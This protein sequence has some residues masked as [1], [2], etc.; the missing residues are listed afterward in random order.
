MIDLAPLDLA[1]CA[2]LIGEPPDSKR[3]ELIYAEGGGNPFYSLQLGQSPAP[4]RSASGDQIASD[5]GVPAL[6]AATLLEELGA[7][8]ADARLLLE[9]AAIAGDPFEPELAYEVA[10]LDPAAGI[11]ALDELLDAKLL[12]PT[13]VPRRFAFRHPLVR[14]AVYESAKAGWRLSAHGRAAAAMQERGAAPL[15]RAHHVEYSAVQGDQQAIVTLTDAAEASQARSPQGSVRWYGAALRLVPA[16][17]EERR[18]ALVTS[19]AGAQRSTGDLEGARTS[20]LAALEVIAEDDP[21]ASLRLT[22]ACAASEHF[23]GR[24]D[25]AQ[26]R[27]HAAFDALPSPDSDAGVEALMALATGA[28]FTMETEPMCDFARRASEGA[29]SL[30]DDGLL[31]AGLALLAHAE[32]LSDRFAE[33]ENSAT[34]AEHLARELSE[35]ALA[36]RLDGVN[37]LAWAALGLQ[38]FEDSVSHAAL[39]V[40]VARRTGQDRFVPLLLSAQALG[41][42][43]L[44]SLAV[45]SEL[46]TEALEIAR[47]A[48]NDYVTC[49]VLTAAGHVALAAGELERA[50][51]YGEESVERVEVLPG[52]RIP[53]MAAVRL[54]VLRREMGEPC[55]L[56]NLAELAG[57]WDLPL[58][59]LW[60]A[61]YLEALTRAALADGDQGEAER[62]VTAAEAAGNGGLALDR[63]FGMRAQAAVELAGGDPGAAADHALAA[64]AEAQRVGARAEAARS[65]A[66]AG[67]AQ[68]AAGEREQGVAT[69]RAAELELGQLG[70]TRARADVRR[71][72]RRLGA[73]AETRGPV[74][75]GI[76]GIESLS[77]RE[78][79]V[80]ELVR[81]RKTN[82][83][84]AADLFLSEK[85]IET[86]LRNIFFKLEVSSRVEVARVVEREERIA[87]P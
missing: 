1:G 31:F 42:M 84:I 6:V 27:L 46:A 23:L 81:D 8:G 61:G 37:R 21:S 3:A 39:G 87:A 73:R 20:L 59:P 35:D 69:L 38:R 77:T 9:A 14:R 13:A 64:A 7:L 54:A 19:L 17:D 52:R 49:S 30:D 78:R 67:R 68:V 74:A 45:A 22:A 24:H 10:E 32:S 11:D 48:A 34:E 33:A 75:E 57:G 80:A 4:V 41:Q 66:L 18:L 85:T 62:Y 29:R 15:E 86:H 71:E 56:T 72:L 44:G 79:E 12:H 36:E 70:A 58:I 55:D 76:S 50:R 2:E 47:I 26:R 43:F 63:A 5:A 53:T 16:D 28:F 65:R 60:R 82:K 83:L 51:Q 40:R 25:D